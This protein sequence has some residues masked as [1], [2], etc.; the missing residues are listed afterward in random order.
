MKFSFHHD[1]KIY[2]NNSVTETSKSRYDVLYK[3]F[4]TARLS[5]FSKLLLFL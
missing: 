5:L 1:A 3:S 2:I 4:T